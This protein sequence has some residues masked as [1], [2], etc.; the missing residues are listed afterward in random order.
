MSES[1]KWTDYVMLHFIVLIWGVTAI[2]GKLI[3]IPAVEV[4]FYRTL[5]AALGLCVLLIVRKR[6]FNI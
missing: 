1:E 5:I 4:V 6:S 3:T 2:L